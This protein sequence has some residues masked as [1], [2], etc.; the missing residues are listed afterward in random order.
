MGFY[1]VC[2]GTDEYVM[3]AP[4]FDKM[5][6]HLPKGKKLE[7]NAPGNSDTNRYVQQLKVNGKKYNKNYIKHADLLKGAKMNYVMS[8]K[9]NTHRGT[10]PEAAPY[11]FSKE[12]AGK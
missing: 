11:S 2:P 1:P 8:D 9:P 5:T 12:L 4:Y 7:I 3:G 6:V 10:E